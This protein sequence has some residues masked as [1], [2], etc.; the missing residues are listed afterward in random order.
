MFMT[1]VLKAQLIVRQAENKS[2][3]KN[4]P[5]QLTQLQGVNPNPVGLQQ[6][7]RLVVHRVW[8]CL[9]QG[10]PKRIERE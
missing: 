9:H 8:A 1:M 10:Q 7:I 2:T 3:V 4:Q 6:N 5:V